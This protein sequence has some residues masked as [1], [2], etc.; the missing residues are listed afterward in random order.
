MRP[1]ADGGGSAGV[2]L[3]AMMIV[4]EELRH[5]LDG[6]LRRSPPPTYVQDL[7]AE[8]HRKANAEGRPRG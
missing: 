2:D 7:L 4:G 3:I 1:V 8:L 5:R 6:E